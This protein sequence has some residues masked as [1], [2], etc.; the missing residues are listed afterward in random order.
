MLGCRWLL[1]GLCI[2]GWVVAVGCMAPFR[3]S[4]HW[5]FCV[6]QEWVCVCIYLVEVLSDSKVSASRN[7]QVAVFEVLVL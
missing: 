5:N 4:G 7:W 1:I 2:F 3:Q 6:M